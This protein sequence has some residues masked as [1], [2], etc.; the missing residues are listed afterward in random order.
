MKTVINALVAFA[1]IAGVAGAAQATPS[2][3]KSTKA[4]WEQIEKNAK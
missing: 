4:F 3:G 2:K 1:F